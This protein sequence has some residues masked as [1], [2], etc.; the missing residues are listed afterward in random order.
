[1][2]ARI[3]VIT[4]N[5]YREAVRARL[6]IGVFGLAL[7]TCFYSVVVGAFSLHNEVRVV[8]DLGAASLSLYGVLIAVVLGSTSLYRELEHKTVFP[9][10]SRPIRRW[11]YLVGKYLGTMLTVTVFVAIDAAAILGTLALEAGQN[12]SKVAGPF[13]AMLGV[14]GIAIARARYRRVFVVIPW[15]VILAVVMWSVASPALED[16]QLVV[17]GALLSIC[18]VAI[19]AA[20]ATL[21]AS[22]SSPFLTA[23]FTAGVFAIGRSADMLAHFPKKMFGQAVALG[24]AGI[25]RVVPNLHVYV[26]PRPLLLGQ[27]AGQP[28]WRYVG[29]AAVHSAFYATALL[30]AGALAFRKRDFS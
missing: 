11:E 10:L 17:A 18:E 22:F 2:V 21:F 30:V 5:T 13:G 8:A 23:T 7:A 16:R 6:L 14:L 27:V 25:A 26:P 12:T 24:F 15:S 29:V 4:L 1:M 28:V 9:I 20:L 19:V 3:L